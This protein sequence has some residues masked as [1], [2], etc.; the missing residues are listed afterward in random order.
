MVRHQALTLASDLHNLREVEKLLQ[1]LIE[2]Y[3]ISKDKY[4]DMLIS[5]TEAVS[6]AIRHGNRLDKRKCVH[7]SFKIEGEEI[8]FRVM[9][10]GEGFDYHSLPD[11]TEP[12]N[13]LRCG[14]RGVFLMKQLS[15]RMSF[16]NNGSTVE[17]CFKTA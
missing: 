15:D 13:L 3:G 7:I 9:D 6:N 14:G 2:E 10:E 11:P 17:M 1:Q 4:A 16:K 5:L 12:E 8:R